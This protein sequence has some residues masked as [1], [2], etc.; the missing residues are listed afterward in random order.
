[1]PPEYSRTE[2]SDS[3]ISLGARVE[4][5]EFLVLGL[6]RALKDNAEGKWAVVDAFQIMSQSLDDASLNRSH[7]HRRI[8]KQTFAEMLL[9]AWG[10]G[11][12]AAAG[13]DAENQS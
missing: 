13:L 11:D 10:K 12:E 4:S 7:A 8:C 6:L 2:Q 9:L 5:L 3:E 1:M